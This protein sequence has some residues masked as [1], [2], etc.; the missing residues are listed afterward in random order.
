M[1]PLQEPGPHDQA[2]G[3]ALRGARGAG[4]AHS[5]AFHTAIVAG[6]K[7]SQ[8]CQRPLPPRLL[9][10]LVWQ[11]L[12]CVWVNA[13]LSDCH[14]GRQQNETDHLLKAA[15]CEP[16]GSGLSLAEPLRPVP[17]L[18]QVPLLQSAWSWALS[19]D[20][21]GESFTLAWSSA[22]EGPIRTGPHVCVSWRE[23]FK[24]EARHSNSQC[25]THHLPS[26]PVLL[27]GGAVEWRCSPSSGRA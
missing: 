25:Y 12:I 10:D 4:P 20:R 14:V 3:A 15:F 11:V 17:A 27:C 6:T 16:P 2:A 26:L 8:R 18:W 22:V 9:R 5:A 24:A 7:R 1:Q 21:P 23:L 19:P 13:A